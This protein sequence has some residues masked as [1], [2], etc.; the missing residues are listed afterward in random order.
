MGD[1]ILTPVQGLRDA[2]E[3]GKL[4]LLRGNRIEVPIAEQTVP[5]LELSDDRGSPGKAPELDDQNYHAVQD[6]VEKALKKG[7]AV[8][9][10]PKAQDHGG[11]SAGSSG[12]EIPFIH[13]LTT[14]PDGSPVPKARRPLDTPLDIWN[15]YTPKEKED[16]I[17]RYVDLLEGVEDAK[18]RRAAAKVA[19]MP[20]IAASAAG[21]RQ[22]TDNA[23]SG[24]DRVR[25]RELLEDKLEQAVF[26]IFGMVA[27]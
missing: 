22:P 14:M 15:I 2:I 8:E 20:V 13:D 19:A 21:N 25:M 3:I 24:A 17:K 5:A 26:D 11:D 7:Q 27:T 18:R 16:G 1:Y 10:K 23:G 6:R 9:S 12:I 4:S